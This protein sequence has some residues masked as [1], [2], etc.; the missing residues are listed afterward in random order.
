[1]EQVGSHSSM[2][3]H[4]KDPRAAVPRDLLAG[5]ADRV[6]RVSGVARVATVANLGQQDQANLLGLLLPP[7]LPLRHM[8]LPVNRHVAAVDTHSAQYKGSLRAKLEG[9]SHLDPNNNRLLADTPPDLKS[10]EL[11]R[12]SDVRTDAHLPALNKSRNDAPMADHSSVLDKISDTLP[13]SQKRQ[14][15]LED[16]MKTQRMSQKMM[17]TLSSQTKTQSRMTSSL[18]TLRRP[19][20]PHW[21]PQP[22]PWRIRLRHSTQ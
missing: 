18:S 9:I 16:I 20:W 17:A 15:S 22:L 1:M 10:P 12:N 5:T 3:C 21:R 11:R 19:T 14:W 4:S 8:A 7:V 13:S 2:T 6:A